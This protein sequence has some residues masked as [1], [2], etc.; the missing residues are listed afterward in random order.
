M[1]SRAMSE[2]PHLRR[3]SKSNPVEPLIIDIQ[4]K[5]LHLKPFSPADAREAFDA[6]TPTLTRF[7]AFDPPL[8][9][10]AFEAVWRQWLFTI[11]D[12]SDLTFVIR[13]RESG[14]F[15]GL[16][17][18]H[19]TQSPEPELGIWVSEQEHGHGYGLEAVSAVLAWGVAVFDPHAFRYPVAEANRASRRIAEK[20]CGHVVD[21][22]ITSKYRSVIY[23]IPSTYS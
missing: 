16:A 17:G 8:S 22:E 11:A 14:D 6:I 18:L 3:F 9:R 23:R 19:N 20:L 15:I 5:R 13:H 7:M 2:A 10:S 21:H 4:T 12:G 1:V